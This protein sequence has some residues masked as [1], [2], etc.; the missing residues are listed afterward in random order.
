MKFSCTKENFQHALMLSG[1]LTGKNVSL[2][3]LSNVL[4]RVD[5][6]KIELVATNLELA[7]VVVVRGKVDAPGSFTVPARTL[8]EFIGLLPSERVDFTLEGGELLVAC[9]K[10]TT[11]IKGTSA[12][13]FPVLPA[14]A[15]GTGF[16]VAANEL[17]RALSRVLPAVAKNEIR[18]E[19]AGVFCGFNA[20][21]TKNL[22]CA[23][24]DSY[25]L[26][27]QVVPLEQGSEQLRA[28][29]PG[30]TAQELVRVLAA[31]SEGE[32]HIRLLMS[33]N[34]LVAHYDSVQIISRLVAGQYPDYTQIIPQQF[35]TTAVVETD[36][37]VKKIKA[38]GLFTTTGVNAVALS[39]D[40]AT[41]S[42]QTNSTS[43]QTGEYASNIEADVT[44]NNVEVLLNH[45]Y[46]LD[47]LAHITT[48]QTKLQIVNAESPCLFTSTTADG[49]RYIV[50]PIRQ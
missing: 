34:Q 39:V 8:Q 9:G 1:G 40:A 22:V 20:N 13:E 33:E 5:E 41:G 43:Q 12:E 50:M 28:V 25:R 11:K 30:R 45:R 35:N 16:V 15:G 2:P 47:G 32:K 6:Q 21:G 10:T 26:A 19:L 42:I 18:P 7:M 14:V 49:F 48:A 31:E 17:E 46:I 23:A 24:T 4:I 36:T 37:L 29:L 38:A 27:E 44:G 3:I